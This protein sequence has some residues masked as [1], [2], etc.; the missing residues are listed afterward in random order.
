MLRDIALGRFVP[1]ESVVHRLDPRTKL[2]VAGGAMAALFADSGF[3]VFL[4]PGLLLSLAVALCGLPVRLLARNLRPFC[5]LLLLTLC[6]NSF[7]IPGRPIEELRLFGQAPSVEGM[8]QG[9]FLMLRLAFMVTI[10]SVVS[11]TTAPIELADGV[12]RCL[13][14]LE[15]LRF[16]AH[17]AAMMTMIALRFIPTL[18]DEAE[19]LKK[20]QIARG[21]TFD[22]GPVTRAKRLLPL[23]V[24]LF[25]SAFRHAD[26]LAVA[27]EVR[28]YQ[29]NARRSNY[30][31][32][33]LGRGDYLA[34]A[35]ALVILAGGLVADRY[36]PLP[37]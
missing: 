26:Q 31:V 12:E 33:Q 7:L 29:S 10:A 6:L 18:I 37:L 2:F 23:L 9:A 28:G 24:P 35:G 14:P 36:C 20:A 27:M 16:P 19:R 32:L 15:R 25:V 8:R 21:A 17:Q 5:Y 30:S 34:M 13:R 11:L 3:S 22:G 1:A 4:A